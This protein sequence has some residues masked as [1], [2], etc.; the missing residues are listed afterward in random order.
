LGEDKPLFSSPL[1]SA[2][3]TAGAWSKTRPAVLFVASADGNILV[4]DFTD[5]SF[6]PS[7]ELK[8]AHAKITSLE[9][10]TSSATARH[11]LLAVGDEMGTLHIFEMPRNLIKPV[12]KEESIMLKFLERELQV[13][14]LTC[15]STFRSCLIRSFTFPLPYSESN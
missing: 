5:S 4:W 15:T 13:C 9:L 11:Q 2:Y 12:H 7:I 8:A 6:H 14:Y 1:S 3:L 10:L